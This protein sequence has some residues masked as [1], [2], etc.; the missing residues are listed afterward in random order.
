MIT[1]KRYFSNDFFAVI[2]TIKCF[3][4]FYNESKEVE[5]WYNIMFIKLI[6]KF[7]GSLNTRRVTFE[8]NYITAKTKVAW[9]YWKI[10]FEL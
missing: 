9:M 2:W 1:S 10:Y 6:V 3:S 7:F 8:E 5:C 4:Q